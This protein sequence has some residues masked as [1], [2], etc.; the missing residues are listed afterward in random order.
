MK[1]IFT[2]NGFLTE[3]ASEDFES[4]LDKEINILLNQ[5]LTENEAR[6]IGS[7]ICKRVQD[8]VLERITSF[9]YLINKDA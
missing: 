6:V 1:K 3:E 8:K 7:L 4:Y 9:R 5:A 2:D